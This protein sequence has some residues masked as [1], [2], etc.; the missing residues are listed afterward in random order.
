MTAEA[1]TRVDL[2]IPNDSEADVTQ[3][4][5]VYGVPRELIN[6]LSLSEPTKFGPRSGTS[7]AWRLLRAI[8]YGLQ[9]GTALAAFAPPFDSSHSQ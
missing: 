9:G 6:K 3:L 2:G 4:Q 8:K 1:R 7:D 5:R